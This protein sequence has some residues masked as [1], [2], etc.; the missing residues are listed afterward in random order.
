MRPENM[1]SDDSRFRSLLSLSGAFCMGLLFLVASVTPAQAQDSDP[2][3]Q[4]KLMH[5]SLYWEDFKNE[6][7]ESA[8]GD[9]LWIIEHAPGTPQGDDRNFERVVKLYEGLAKQAEDPKTR[10][11]Y[12]DTAA[13]YLTSAVQR[14]E[15]LGL[16]YSTLDWEIMKGQF[17]ER[18]QDNL[19]DVEGLKS[20]V[21]HY[22]NA[23]EAAPKEINPY[24]I[25]RI[26]QSYLEE[27][28]LQKA[29]SFA[30]T[31]EAKRGDDAKVED[32]I[33]SV[34]EQVFSMNPQ[35][36][37]KHLEKQVENNPDSLKLMTQLFE[38]YNEQGNVEKASELA[39]RLMKMN[40][41][42]ETVRS[43]AQMRLENGK[44]KAALEAYD[45]AAEQGAELSAEDYFNRGSAYQEMGQLAKARS[46]YRKAIDMRSDFGEAYIA[47]GDLY[48]QSVNQ[49]S[50]SKMTRDDK[51]VYWAVV[52]K[53][54]QAKRVDSSIASVANSKIQTYRK[55]FPSTEDIFYRSD[56]EKGNS[57]TIDYGCYSWIGETTTVRPA[58]S[59]G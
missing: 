15:K 28:D 38:A 35:A 40:P 16:E 52:D 43:I 10:T 21:A 9:L 23:F 14:M 34:R 27:N 44:P 49:C 26:L 37:I 24:Y 13:T 22:R 59:S 6:D 29:I 58:P 20:K 50:G 42:A 12:L 17:V 56:W 51:A 57:F 5:Y 32:I 48:S 3:R 4:E 54:Q 39:P 8:R 36:Q 33:S 7:Y 46:E 41:S 55:V 1:F 45:R 2:S 31:V 18:H 11:A 53:Y 30:S 19:P 25:R 47:I